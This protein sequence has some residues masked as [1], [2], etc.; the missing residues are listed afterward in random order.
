MREAEAVNLIR[1]NLQRSEIEMLRQAAE[2]IV[3]A[4]KKAGVVFESN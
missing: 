3:A 4:L 2:R 1:E